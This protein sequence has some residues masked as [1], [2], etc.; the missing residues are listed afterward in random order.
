MGN[1]EQAADPRQ[2]RE[3]ASSLLELA[4][5]V[6]EANDRRALFQQVQRQDLATQACT[7]GLL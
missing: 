1:Q 5:L 6:A 7:G 4:R 3:Q 2:P